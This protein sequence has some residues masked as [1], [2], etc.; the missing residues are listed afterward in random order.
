MPKPLNSCNDKF[1]LQGAGRYICD[2]Q[3]YIHCLPGWTKE[4][5]MCSTPVCH[6]NCSKVHG[7]CIG[8]NTCACDIGWEVINS[9]QYLYW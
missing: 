8:P 6:P 3:G 4:Y 9:S 5:E 2:N 1:Y 7:K